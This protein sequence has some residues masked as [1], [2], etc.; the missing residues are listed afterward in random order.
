[1]KARIFILALSVASLLSANETF[2]TKCSTCHGLKGEKELVGKVG[3]TRPLSSISETEL[4]TLMVGYK[5]GTIHDG[6][7]QHGLGKIMKGQLRPLSKEE[8]NE[9]ASYISKLNH[10]A[11][12]K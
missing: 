1:M 7:G 10:K 3:K 12:E 5:D 2:E 6:D 11:E 4:V 9:L 8:I